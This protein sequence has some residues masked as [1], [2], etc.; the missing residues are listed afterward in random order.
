MMKVSTSPLARCLKTLVLLLCCG[1][2]IWVSG[3]LSFS[4]AAVGGVKE[5]GWN[6]QFLPALYYGWLCGL[7]FTIGIVIFVSSRRMPYHLKVLWILFIP[8]PVIFAMSAIIHW[9]LLLCR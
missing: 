5:G 1:L 3:L 7:L 2:S 8:S 4:G 6:W 9:L